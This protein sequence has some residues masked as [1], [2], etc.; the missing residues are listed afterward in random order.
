MKKVIYAFLLIFIAATMF[1]SCA[2]APEEEPAPEEPEVTLEQ[3]PE[4]KEPET[5]EPEAPQPVSQ[6]ELDKARS[7]IAR[8]EEV[9]AQTY[10]P[11]P[12]EKARED[13]SQ[14]EE[15]A[16]QDPEK[17]RAFLQS[18]QEA[19]EEA[20]QI[21]SEK[22][23]ESLAQRMQSMTEKLKGIKAPL[24]APEEFNRLQEE[25][26][27]SMEAF[28]QSFSEGVN[29]SEATLVKMS[30]F[31]NQL[32]ENI[33]WVKILQRDTENYLSDAESAEAYI[34]AEEK[35]EMAMTYYFEG[36]DAFRTYNLKEGEDKLAQAKFY[37]L[38]AS[39]TAQEQRA[40]K[41]TE[42]YMLEVMK[43]IKEASEMTVV[44]DN[45]QIITPEPWDGETL[46]DS[47]YEEEPLK[48]DPE[49][50]DPDTKEE[51]EEAKTQALLPQKGEVVVL[52]ED[53]LYSY[54]NKAQE[55]WLLGV[56]EKNKG[57]MVLANQFFREAQ[58]YVRLYR[59]KAVDSVYTVKY[60]PD[61]RDCLWRIAQRDDIYDN[62][63]LW[64]KIWR[65]N[66]KLI[67]NPD[68]IYPG[69]NLIIPPK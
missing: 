63:Y 39:R 32:D 21:A 68:L 29:K 26:K 47:T 36:L 38:E 66:R 13:L 34:Y 37:A 57:N 45:D 52:G 11:A 64:P 14:G 44:S 59:D 40:L 22:T 9:G 42:D 7:A 20:Y 55:L 8:A 33:R 23:K 62:P 25:S 10:A 5:P 43:E 12:L 56:K 27:A 61:L 49:V 48:E 17:S 4:E 69:W 2:S 16:T 19:A 65:R 24:Y 15:L 58:S 1:Y 60:N 35:L 53:D 31:Y 67:Q 30:D 51:E 50:E 54:L 3:E 28:D 46:L 18:S 6:E 41:E